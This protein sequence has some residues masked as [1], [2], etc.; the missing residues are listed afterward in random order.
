MHRLRRLLTCRGEPFTSPRTKNS[1]SGC[2]HAQRS[3]TECSALASHPTDDH[4][5]N[6]LDYLASG[7]G[8]VAQHCPH[9]GKE[10]LCVCDFLLLRSGLRR[11]F[12]VQYCPRF[13]RIQAML[14]KPRR[15]GTASG[16]VTQAGNGVE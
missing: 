15:N 9:R 8:R 5:R 6:R 16:D 2:R 12:R 11:H 3:G 1:S 10:A 13:P 7:I 14:S 4:R